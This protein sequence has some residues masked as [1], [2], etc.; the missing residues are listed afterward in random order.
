MATAT[1]ASYPSTDQAIA[2]YNKYFINEVSFIDPS[3]SVHYIPHQNDSTKD[4]ITLTLSNGYC[5]QLKQLNI[6][7]EEHNSPEL[8]MLNLNPSLSNIVHKIVQTD[9]N[10]NVNINKVWRISM[11]TSEHL[12]M[13]ITNEIGLSLTYTPIKD[14]NAIINM[15]VIQEFNLVHHYDRNSAHYEKHM[16][17]KYDPQTFL[18][19]LFDIVNVAKN[20]NISFAIKK[21]I[22]PS[23]L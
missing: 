3:Y 2:E 21:V 23:L 12:G 5:I 19:M 11:G 22:T 10:S 18:Q 15:A 16:L 20:N 17:F 4:S 7:F 1:Y 8:S 14:S 13:D 9:P 6:I